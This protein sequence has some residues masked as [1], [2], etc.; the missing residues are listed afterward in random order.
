MGQI[1]IKFCNGP[2]HPSGGVMLPLSEFN[3]YKTG[4]RAG[5]PISVCRKCRSIQR[6]TAVPSNIY[7]L[8]IDELKGKGFTQRKIAKE[9]NAT[10]NQVS[11]W[12]LR[13]QK[14]MNQAT[15]RK[16]LRAKTILLNNENH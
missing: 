15:F 3:L 5:K 14:R 11:D 8:I 13:K 9:M 10:D 6:R 4:P 16:L 12:A 1:N 2:S 7:G